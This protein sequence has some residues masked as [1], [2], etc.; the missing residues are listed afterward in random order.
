LAKEI[1]PDRLIQ[2]RPDAQLQTLKRAV[3]IQSSQT[4]LRYD[5]QNNKIRGMLSHP[6][7][8]GF[9]R[10]VSRRGKENEIIVNDFVSNGSLVDHLPPITNADKCQLRG[11]TRIAIIVAGVVLGMRYVHSKGI[12]HRKLR[13]STIALDWDWIV[14]LK[15][16][17]HSW[18]VNEPPPALNAMNPL[19]LP[20][21]YT[22]PECYDEVWS[23]KSDVFSFGLI[24]YELLVG[25]PAFSNE[26]VPMQYMYQVVIEKARPCIPDSVLP[27]VRQLIEDCWSDDPNTR[28]SFQSIL[29]ILENMNFKLTPKVDSSKVLRFVEGIKEWE[30]TNRSNSTTCLSTALRAQEAD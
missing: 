29:D 21:G 19:E 23:T 14:H 8:I 7:I 25:K 3:K 9:H 27:E 12:I 20:T 6:L 24:L 22:A 4:D 5:E 10:K 13:P 1:P 11:G 28:P 30:E 17:D 16:F 2:E 26:P 15:G 18:I